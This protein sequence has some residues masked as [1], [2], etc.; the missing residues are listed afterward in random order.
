M[1]LI[2]AVRIILQRSRNNQKQVVNDYVKKCRLTSFTTY[3][4]VLP[5]KRN[6]EKKVEKSKTDRQ[7]A[8]KAIKTEGLVK[9]YCIIVVKA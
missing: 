5:P 2:I 3:F 8:E 7:A 9:K 6:G 1:L 4:K